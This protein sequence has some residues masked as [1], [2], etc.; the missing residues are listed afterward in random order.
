[1]Y[2]FFESSTEVLW[3]CV[4]W[5]SSLLMFWQ[6]NRFWFFCFGS[7][8]AAS[9]DWCM[10]CVADSLLYSCMMAMHRELIVFRFAAT[11]LAFD[12]NSFQM[13]HRSICANQIIIAAVCCS[14]FTVIVRLGK[15]SY[16]HRVD[17]VRLFISLSLDFVHASLS[18]LCQPSRKHVLCMCECMSVWVYE[19][20]SM[21]HSLLSKCL[22]T[23]IGTYRLCI[24]V[25]RNPNLSMC[26]CHNHHRFH[27]YSNLN[28]WKPILNWIHMNRIKYRQKCSR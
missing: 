6:M 4:R 27:L 23:A 22:A 24:I 3:K 19:R 11:L 26:P 1:M 18:L 21:I 15:V 16:I 28:E 12:T 14:L 2:T 7:F 20:G 9:V 10:H 17:C 8:F 25:C 5:C 13:L